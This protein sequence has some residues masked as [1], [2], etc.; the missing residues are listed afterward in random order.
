MRLGLR[1]GGSSRDAGHSPARMKAGSCTVPTRPATALVS[2]LKARA[3]AAAPDGERKAPR[4][5]RT[6]WLSVR[7][8]LSPLALSPDGQAFA[9]PKS[10][11]NRAEAFMAMAKEHGCS[12]KHLWTPRQWP[13]LLLLLSRQLMRG[14]RV[15]VSVGCAALAPLADGLGGHAIAAG[16]NTRG[17]KRTG[18]LRDRATELSTC[19]PA[20]PRQTA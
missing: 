18:D 4:P 2:R 8:A 14:A 16:Q 20:S 7:G 9:T 10:C 11:P 12:V 1:S 3:E 15:V 5:S 19:L 13:A 17:L 6:I